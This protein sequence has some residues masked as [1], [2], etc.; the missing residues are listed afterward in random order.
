M[1]ETVA[2]SIN[3]LISFE[4]LAYVVMLRAYVI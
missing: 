4:I 2:Y 3:A 1:A